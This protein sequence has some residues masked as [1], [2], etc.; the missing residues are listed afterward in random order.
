MV[1]CVAILP[2]SSEQSPNQSFSISGSTFSGGVQTNGAAG[3]DVTR[4]ANQG[5]FDTPPS[6]QE[7]IALLVQLEDLLQQSSLPPTDKQK[8]IQYLDSAREEAQEDEP[9][10]DYALKSFQKATKVIQ[11]AGQTIEATSLLWDNVEGIAQKLAPWF[12]V[13]AKTLL[14]L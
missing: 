12:G 7:A 13:A 1:F 4:Q 14:R 6:Q 8:A 10:K 5:T 2:M 3:G 9:D 11:S